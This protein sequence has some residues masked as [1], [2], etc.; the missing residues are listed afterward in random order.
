MGFISPPMSH[1]FSQYLLIHRKKFNY[2]TYKKK[3]QNI[4]NKIVNKNE[5]QIDH[6]H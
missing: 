6:D 5:Q 4:N 2:T 1:N 3:A